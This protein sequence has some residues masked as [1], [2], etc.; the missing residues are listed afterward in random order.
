[1]TCA[2]GAV[3]GY[4]RVMILMQAAMDSWN[5]PVIMCDEC[6]QRITDVYMAL[7]TWDVV[8]PGQ[9]SKAYYLHKPECDQRFNAGK[10]RPFQELHEHLKRLAEGL[11]LPVD[12]PLPRVKATD[13]AQDV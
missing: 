11:G 7:V 13:Q 9:C 3:R 8:E 4:T 12:W 10:A 5:D 2:A 6:K 1:M